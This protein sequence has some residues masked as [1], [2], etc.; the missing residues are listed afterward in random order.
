MSLYGN[1][2]RKISRLTDLRLSP[3][4]VSHV[5]KTVR[6]EFERRKNNLLSKFNNHPVTVEIEAGPSA[7]NTSGT[8]GGYGNLFSF[9]GFDSGEKPIIPIRRKMEEVFINSINIR[10]DGSFSLIVFNP[11][12]QDIFSIT[13][14]PWASGR[15]WA[16]GV[17]RGLPGF[18]WYLNKNFIKSNSGE[19][20]QVKN[21]VRDSKFQNTQYITKLIRDFEKSILQMNN[22]TI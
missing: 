7:K 9:I 2:Q 5:K 20:I 4:Y 6:L 18:G 10:K 19:G 13:P 8:L 12:P 14:L 15:S 22:L 3:E 1:S 16:E 17:E 11:S 21:K